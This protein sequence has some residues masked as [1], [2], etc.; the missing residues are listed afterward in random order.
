M[1]L[2]S[3]NRFRLHQWTPAA[4]RR[5]TRVSHSRDYGS[6]SSIDHFNPEYEESR[7]LLQNKSIN[8]SQPFLLTFADMKEPTPQG[9]DLGKFSW[10]ITRVSVA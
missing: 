8:Q 5:A 10:D 4:P 9:T 6:A 1:N 7:E 2:T 3:E